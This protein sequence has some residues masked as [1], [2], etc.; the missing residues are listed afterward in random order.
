MGCRLPTEGELVHTT[1]T[2]ERK[3]QGVS[4]ETAIAVRE[5]KNEEK[6]EN[7]PVH[8]CCVGD[9]SHH[10]SRQ[11]TVKTSNSFLG[12]D[13]LEGLKK[14]GISRDAV[15]DGLT[16]TSSEDLLGFRKTGKRWISI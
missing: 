15:N 7:E 12:D 5:K 9:D 4:I 8:R 3:Q 10:V 13:E 14:A 1:C 11:T 6:T 16:E 2:G